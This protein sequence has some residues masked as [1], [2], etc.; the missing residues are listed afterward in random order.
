MELENYCQTGINSVEP[1]LDI[2]YKTYHFE[3]PKWRPSNV[4]ENF[5]K[6]NTAHSHYSADFDIRDYENTDVEVVLETLF[7]DSRLH[8]TEKSLR[9]IACAQPFILA[10]THGS[11]EYL[12]SYGFKTFDH[13]W[14]ESY[15]LIEDPEER[16]IRIADLM[17]QIANWTPEQ[18]INNLAQAQAIADYN[19]RHFFSE[20][21]FNNITN[22]LKTNLFDAF[23]EIENCNRSKHYLSFRDQILSNP[24]TSAYVKTRRTEEEAAYVFNIALKHNRKC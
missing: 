4:L 19:K 2:H 7:D 6:I 15:D 24:V 1:E 12:H 16:L 18:R 22:E 8:L 17:R 14:D 10:G 13:I 20:T 21:F 23:V 5:F 3:N 9:P 11:L